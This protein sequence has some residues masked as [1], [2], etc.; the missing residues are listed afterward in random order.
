MEERLCSRTL[1]QCWSRCSS[2]T[3]RSSKLGSRNEQKSRDD[4]R[5]IRRSGGVAETAGGA[6]FQCSE[7]SE[8]CPRNTGGRTAAARLQQGREG[9]AQ[10]P[11][12]LSRWRL[13]PLLVMW[14]LIRSQF[15]GC[16]QEQRFTPRQ[17]QQLWAGLQRQ[18]P[19][20]FPKQQLRPTSST[21]ENE[22]YRCP[23][24]VLYLPNSHCVSALWRETPR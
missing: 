21:A 20:P 1:G 8:Q 4:T 6:G 5:C 15:S 17:K 18:Q 16:S 14:V 22:S 23:S 9:R 3:L 24:P 10:D 2:R 19:I 11:W 7:S 12:Y 13:V